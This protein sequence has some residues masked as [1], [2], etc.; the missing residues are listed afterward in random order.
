MVE[1]HWWK[2]NKKE[3][4]Q[5]LATTKHVSKGVSII[6]DSDE[7]F[8][9]VI[10]EKEREK[11]QQEAPWIERIADDRTFKQIMAEILERYNVLDDKKLEEKNRMMQHMLKCK[12]QRKN[13]QATDLCISKAVLLGNRV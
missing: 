4:I 10:D 1:E 9:D 7:D 11:E 5:K 6:E 3:T 8:F 2:K 12:A 13:Q